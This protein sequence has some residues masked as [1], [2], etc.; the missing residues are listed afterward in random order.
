MKL[1]VPFRLFSAVEAAPGQSQPLSTAAD[2][3]P[4]GTGRIC[5]CRHTF[6]RLRQVTKMY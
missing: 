3:F 2:I 5:R 6:E 1:K 4:G